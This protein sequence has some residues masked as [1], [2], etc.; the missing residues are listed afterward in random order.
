M[1]C[2]VEEKII[3][4]SMEIMRCWITDWANANGK[5][6]PDYRVW[7]GYEDQKLFAYRERES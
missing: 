5:I 2:L 1:Q 7:W 3:L 4:S 6:P